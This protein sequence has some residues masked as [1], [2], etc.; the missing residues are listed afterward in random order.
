MTKN[1]QVSLKRLFVAITLLA[2]ILAAWRALETYRK[3]DLCRGYERSHLGRANDYRKLANDEGLSSFQK[4]AYLSAAEESEDCAK[5]YTEFLKHPWGP[6]PW[7]T[8]AWKKLQ[9]KYG[10]TPKI[11]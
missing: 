6:Y 11:P 5:V 8:D 7:K 4:S 10:T 3:W 1:P 9:D 2:V